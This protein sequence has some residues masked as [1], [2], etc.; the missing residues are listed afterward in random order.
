MVVDASTSVQLSP[1]V[2]TVMPEGGRRVPEK[3]GDPP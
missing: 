2:L 1:A 3:V